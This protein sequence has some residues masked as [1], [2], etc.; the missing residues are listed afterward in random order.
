MCRAI[1]CAWIETPH[2]WEIIYDIARVAPS[3]A[4]GLKRARP[5]SCISLRP[6]VAPS[7]ARGLKHKFVVGVFNGDDVSRHHVRV[8]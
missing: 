3:R 6:G 7:R 4:R 1:T 8:D 5:T 2:Q